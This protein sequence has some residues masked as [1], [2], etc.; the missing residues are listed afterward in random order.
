[1]GGYICS[2][3]PEDSRIIPL[4]V[5]SRLLPITS[6]NDTPTS[7][8]AKN[9]KS[10]CYVAI[11]DYI[12]NDFTDMPRGRTAEDTRVYKLPSQ[13]FNNQISLRY[14]YWGFRCISYKLFSNGQMQFTGI[15]DPKWE[16]QH[17]ATELLHNI[18]KLK[19]I[20][21]DITKLKTATKY[22]TENNLDYI[23]VWDST[24][25]KVTYR[26]RNLEIYDF[27][28]IMKSGIVN[29]NNNSNNNNNDSLQPDD[30]WYDHDSAN[31]LIEE[32]FKPIDH[33]KKHLE[34]IMDRLRNIPE[35]TYDIRK[36]IF[37]NEDDGLGRYQRLTSLDTQFI[38]MPDIEFRRLVQKTVKKILKTFANY[39]DRLRKLITTDSIIANNVNDKHRRSIMTKIRTYRKKNKP[40]PDYFEYDTEMTHKKYKITD[41]NIDLI[42]S[43]FNTQYIN[44]LPI[45]SVLLKQYGIYNYYQPNNKYPGIIA[46]FAYNPRYMNN[47]ADNTTADTNGVNAS[48]PTKYQ[49][50]KC[51]C[52]PRCVAGN[53]TGRN[54]PEGHCTFITVNI[55]RTGSIMITSARTIEQ[56]QYVY[57][58]IN[59][60][61]HKNAN[62]VFQDFS[63]DH[64]FAIENEDRNI[65]KKNE[66]HYIPVELVP[67]IDM[68][69]TNNSHSINVLDE[70]NNK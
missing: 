11:S 2:D 26:R 19:Y 12:D 41:I 62:R 37:E 61:F 28:G 32:Y 4:H 15:M 57:E 51:Y 44:L 18:F 27:N 56:I 31:T 38:R 33:E 7:M 50:G 60:F 39:E 17:I 68:H 1:M 42:N 5:F 16:P 3:L 59:Q 53:K 67:P 47:N 65:I 54:I 14:K 64:N 13:V 29:N 48:K 69:N 10:G 40:L 30:I 24:N 20:I 9:S 36:A 58:W 22:A 21:W 49:P 46:R 23:L 43:D 66:L 25:N 35:F 34:N 6:D 55:F 8:N 70:T 52:T 45:I 63:D